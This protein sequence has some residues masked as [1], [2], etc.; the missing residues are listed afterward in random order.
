MEKSILENAVCLSCGRQYNDNNDDDDDD[1]D[2]LG[3]YIFN[4]ECQAAH[5]FHGIP[6][7]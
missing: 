5:F 1:D 2:D 6:K 4:L 7:K 3:A